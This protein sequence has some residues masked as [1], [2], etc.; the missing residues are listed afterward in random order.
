MHDVL[1][2]A[3][4][5]EVKQLLKV[6]IGKE[7]ISLSM[8]KSQP[9][10]SF[11]LCRNY[12]SKSVDVKKTINGSILRITQTCS[13]HNSWVW[14]SQPMIG[15]IPAE[16]ISLP[17]TILFAGALPVKALRSFKH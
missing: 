16:N 9:S 17:A 8:L 12:L 13:C 2:G 14:D 1:E 3:L 5:L 4:E 7:S 15:N 11:S 6:Y 10:T